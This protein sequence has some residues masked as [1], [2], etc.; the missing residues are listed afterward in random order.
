MGNKNSG[1]STFQWTQE[2]DDILRTGWVAGLSASSIAGRLTK[3]MQRLFTR[4]AVIGRSRRLEMPKR[5]PQLAVSSSDNIL[6]KKPRQKRAVFV[7]AKTV[8]F[9]RSIPREDTWKGLGKIIELID[10]TPTNCH[11]PVSTDG[12]WDSP[13]DGFCGLPADE[14]CPYCKEHRAIAYNPNSL[15][16]SA[17]KS[18]GH[19]K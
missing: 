6:T 2:A 4:N 8:A 16:S 13:A 3:A 11:W 18:Y 19:W 10:T 17:V 9:E 7:K 1:R 15:R 5:G 14:G 12:G